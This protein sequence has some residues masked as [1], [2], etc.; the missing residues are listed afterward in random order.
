MS[1]RSPEKDLQHL[2]ADETPPI[3]GSPFPSAAKAAPKSRDEKKRE[4]EAVDE[5]LEDS[6]PASDPPAF[7]R[8]TGV[9]VDD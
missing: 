7:T 4:D 2:K 1:A 3:A 5:A 6:F 9:K 8:T